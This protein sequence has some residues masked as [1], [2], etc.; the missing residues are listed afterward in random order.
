VATVEIGRS[1][2]GSRDSWRRY[3][4]LVDGEEVGRLSRGESA[5]FHVGLGRHVVQVV[6]DWKRSAQ[7][8]IDGGSDEMSRLRCGPTR[9]A[10][11]AAIDFFKR[12][13]NAWLFLAP[14]DA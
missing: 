12:G 11:W 6:I 13:D 8:V 10:V 9:G 14:E 3:R 4:V 7:F 5:R 1:D 2:S